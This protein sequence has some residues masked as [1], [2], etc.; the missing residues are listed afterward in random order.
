MNTD[1]PPPL[2]PSSP[3]A[4][5][6]GNGKNGKK[7]ALGCSL[8]CLVSLVITGVVGYFVFTGIKNKVVDA[9]ASYTSEQ[10]V[11]IVEPTTPEAEVTDAI[12]RFDQFSADMSAGK[13]TEPL[14]L[15]ESDINA[16][17]FNHSMF[18]AAA[19][20]GIVSI[21]DNKLTSTISLN[22]DDMN[23]PVP[24]IAEA[25]KGRYFNGVATLS[26]GMTAGRPG[27]FMEELRFNGAPLPREIMEGFRQE[28][29]MKDAYKNPEMKGFFDRIED[30]S[31]EYDQLKIIPKTTES[32]N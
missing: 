2:T 23:I 19:G 32:A 17:L 22:L 14:V 12:A 30:I 25:V 13:T 21:T 16:L 1:S 20:K 18:K 10:P 15:S 29:L 3:V 26:L 6:D 24:F 31:I 9:A 7:V 5:P 27:L 4:E 28:N 11:A 8:G